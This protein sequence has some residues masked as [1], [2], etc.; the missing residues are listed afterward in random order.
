MAAIEVRQP[1]L[2]IDLIYQRKAAM[3]QQEIYGY[4]AQPT[5]IGLAPCGRRRLVAVG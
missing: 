1:I 2:N 4:K 5:W 3:K